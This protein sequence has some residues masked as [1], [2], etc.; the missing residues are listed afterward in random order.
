MRR[1]PPELIEV[2][3]RQVLCQ[4]EVELASL[5]MRPFLFRVTVTGLPPHA[6]RRIYEISA[7]SDRL[8]AEKAMEQFSREMS[9]PRTMQVYTPTP[10]H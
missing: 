8:A 5:V 1:R 2:P 7:N 3:R 9:S 10:W 6:E 4:C